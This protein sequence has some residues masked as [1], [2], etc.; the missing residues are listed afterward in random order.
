[1]FKTRQDEL[2]VGSL[3]NGINKEKR[4]F[5]W[6]T[7]VNREKCQDCYAKFVCGGECFVNAYYSS[8]SITEKDVLLCE[9]KRYLYKLSLMF[10]HHLKQMECYSVI[11]RGCVNKIKRFDE[12]KEVTD[13]LKKNP[14]V[15]FNELKYNRDLYD[16]YKK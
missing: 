16:I 12:D 15:S 13:F 3:E 5:L 14:D 9:L 8:N 7:L 6:N 11:V 1:L 4:E 10:N 2:V